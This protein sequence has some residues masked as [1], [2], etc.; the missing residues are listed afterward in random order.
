LKEYKSKI[1]KKYIAR[2]ASLAFVVLLSLAP[3][4]VHGQYD[5]M[6]VEGKYW[7][8]INLFQGAHDTYPPVSGHAITFLGDTVINSVSY[9][10]VY[11]HLLKGGHPC[12][13]P[14]C[15]QFDY[16]YQTESKSLIAFIRED[17][18][19]RKIYNL[20]FPNTYGFCDTVE[21]LLFDFSLQIGDTINSC[22]YDFIRASDV[23]LTTG[24]IVD[25][26]GELMVFEKNRRTI[27]T[28]GFT[29]GP[30]AYEMR[31]PII[32][33]FGLENYGIFLNP[34]S[35]VWDFCENG[36]WDCQLIS[37]NS[38]I[39]SETEVKIFPNPTDGLARISIHEE[40]I[41][42]LRLFSYLGSL[43]SETNKSNTIDLSNSSI[44]VYFLEVIL[45]NDQRILRKIIKNQ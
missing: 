3:K 43:I 32:E 45:K 26:T 35:Y 7:I 19:T 24:G 9:K 29:T 28:T 4:I 30:D 22:I 42:C 44:G 39:E 5:P 23:H 2:V 15:W 36:T 14:P 11:K 6:V 34:L 38:T 16:P 31:I 25:S 20:P 41:K 27:F 37:S 12:M 40:D 33:G 21:H 10:K 1:F 13:Y 18:I 8:Y 17:T